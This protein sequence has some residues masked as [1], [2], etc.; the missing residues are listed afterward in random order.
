MPRCLYATRN[1]CLLLSLALG[2]EILRGAKAI[3]QRFRLLV[4]V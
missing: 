3:S 4:M 1:C 2:H